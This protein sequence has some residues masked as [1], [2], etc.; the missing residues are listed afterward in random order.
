VRENQ[1]KEKAYLHSLIPTFSLR[2]KELK[3]PSST[4]IIL[5]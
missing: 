3:S 4:P 2:E 5:I 1:N